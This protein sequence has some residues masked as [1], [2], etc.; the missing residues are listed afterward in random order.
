MLGVSVS[1][2]ASSDGV[3][4]SS[5]AFIRPRESAEVPTV[6]CAACC[7]RPVSGLESGGYSDAVARRIVFGGRDRV[8]RWVKAEVAVERAADGHTLGFFAI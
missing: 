3:V 1:T 5:I 4:A 2:T 6:T 7:R 8:L